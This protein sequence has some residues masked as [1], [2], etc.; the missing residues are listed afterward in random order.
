MGSLGGMLSALYSIRVWTSL[1]RRALFLGLVGSQIGYECESTHLG[2]CYGEVEGSLTQI[3][4][5]GSTTRFICSGPRNPY[6]WVRGVSRTCMYWRWWLRHLLIISG[7][8][9]MV[10]MSW[11]GIIYNPWMYL[12]DW[13]GMFRKWLSINPSAIGIVLVVCVVCVFDLAFVVWVWENQSG[14]EAM[15]IESVVMGPFAALLSIWG[16]FVV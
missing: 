8:W 2:Q 11:V 15:Y 14:V 9:V 13:L 10:V 5:L 7:V 4:E 1:D 3:P 16:G 12:C 6:I